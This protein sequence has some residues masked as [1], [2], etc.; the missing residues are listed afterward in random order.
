MLPMYYVHAPNVLR[1][2]SQCTTYMLP[3]YYVHAKTADSGD[4]EQTKLVTISI[5]SKQ[6]STHSGHIDSTYLWLYLAAC[7]LVPRLHSP[8]FY[9][10]WKNTGPC[11]LQ[12]VKYTGQWSLGTRLAACIWV[13]THL[14]AVVGEPLTS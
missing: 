8:A 9:A 11:F 12:S 6:G 3:M 1:T 5:R 13:Y 4:W 14:T 10:L 7:S 2:C